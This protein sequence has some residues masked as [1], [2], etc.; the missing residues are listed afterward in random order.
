M[1]FVG[2]PFDN[3]GAGA[4]WVFVQ[5]LNVSAY[6]G[7]VASGTQGGPFK[8]PSFSYALSAASGSVAYAITGVPSWLTASSTSGTVTRSKK[9]IT[10]KINAS[11]KSL[12][13]GAYVGAIQFDTADGVQAAIS[14]AATLT[15]NPV[16]FKI[17]VRASPAGGGSVSG[18]GS[19]AQGTSQTVQAAANS[20]YEFVHW[21]KSGKAVS[22]SA[23]YT[24]TLDAS[25]TLIADFRRS[26]AEGAIE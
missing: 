8:P 17:T 20:G 24:F 14:R 6:P 9:I 23:S 16:Q 2:G 3:S 11:A 5:P 26:L 13:P 1:A 15:V 10:F 7:V 4:A 25:V 19:F 18:G 21:T 12:S 22:T